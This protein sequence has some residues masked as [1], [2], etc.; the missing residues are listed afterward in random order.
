MVDYA[1]YRFKAYFVSRIDGEWG[2]YLHSISR[3]KAKTSYMEMNP[4]VEEVRFIDISATREPFFD[5]KPFTDENFDAR[6]SCIDREDEEY[7]PE[8]GL[9]FCRCRICSD[10]LEKIAAK[11]GLGWNMK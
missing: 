2:M 8:I 3:G 5:D 9:M 6:G 1:F 11:G 7:V 10:A 4:D